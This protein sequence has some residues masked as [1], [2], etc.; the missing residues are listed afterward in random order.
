LLDL[1]HLMAESTNMIDFMY[2]GQLFAERFAHSGGMRLD[3][4]NATRLY[5]HLL[6]LLLANED[7]DTLRDA[8]DRLALQDEQPS[9]GIPKL[10][11]DK[12]DQLLKPCIYRL[13][14]VLSARFTRYGAHEDFERAVTIYLVVM[15]LSE[16]QP[17]E[18]RCHPL[19]ILSSLYANHY[20]AFGDVADLDVSVS[21]AERASGLAKE[22]SPIK[23]TALA[24]LANACGVRFRALSNPTDLER[25]IST[26]EVVDTLT[27]DTHPMKF[28]FLYG[29]G[30]DLSFFASADADRPQ[31]EKAIELQKRGIA[32]LP[33]AHRDLYTHIL[34]LV[35]SLRSHYNHFA[36]LSSLDGVINILR[37]TLQLVSQ[38]QVITRTATLHQIGEALS[39][40]HAHCGESE[41]LSRAI[42]F[43]SQ[44][45]TIVSDSHPERKC[46]LI[47]LSR[48]LLLL[49]PPD[50]DQA[51]SILQGY[52]QSPQQDVGICIQY[53]AVLRSRRKGN[54][55]TESVRILQD[56]FDNFP[57]NTTASIPLL[58]AL[59]KSLQAQVM[60]RS[61]RPLASDWDSIISI[62]QRVVDAT[63]QDSPQRAKHLHDLGEYHAQV[64]LQSMKPLEDQFRD[65]L[66]ASMDIAAV[67]RALHAYRSAATGD[68]G[69]PPVRL[70][71][72]FAWANLAGLFFDTRGA[73]EGY[74]VALDMFTRTAWLQSGIVGRF[75]ELR[76]FPNVAREAAHMAIALDE[77]NAAIEWLETGRSVVWAQVRA[78]RAPLDQVRAVDSGLA[79]EI[80]S[81]S[82]ALDSMGTGTRSRSLAEGLD[83]GS[84]FQL[85]HQ[86]AGKWE[87]LVVKARALPGLTTFLLPKKLDE[88]ASVANT[89][90]I[91]FLT[92][93][94]LKCDALI[95]TKEY[96]SRGIIH[97]PLN[98]MDVDKAEKLSHSLQ[99][100][101]GDANLLVRGSSGARGARPP[102][103]Q[104]QKSFFHKLLAA[105]WMHIVK[106]VLDALSLEVSGLKMY[107][108]TS[109]DRKIGLRS[110][111][112]ASQDVVVSHR[113]IEFPPTSRGRPISDKR[114]RNKSF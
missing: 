1:D 96:P 66:A 58:R 93:F 114:A 50:L 100:F 70:H 24:N 95:I 36:V 56:V 41:D 111:Q 10:V 84:A 21:L 65:G 104:T 20:T 109:I 55:V 76:S 51:A 94:G 49:T 40:R 91:V 99:K 17:S 113:A 101:L 4:D 74:S 82:A 14:Q 31:L 38:D 112:D 18:E 22:D 72:A 92:V 53:A 97:V 62:A 42:S 68:S 57:P 35:N 3:L 30:T 52:V 19:R 5:E 46:I 45:C 67:K 15:A 81:V 32:L 71:A 33:R 39:L 44:A 107:I 79:D 102:G 26:H 75:T 34:G 28:Q 90:P 16:E 60:S 25:C 7:V 85:Y 2:L 6:T 110:G 61:T 106:P 59:C 47:D 86:L 63:P 8:G 83:I 12:P 13:G 105:L 9:S 29:Y 54:D 64:W 77:H 87:A 78:L 80:L 23:V 73:F 27:P 89:G 11:R 108:K 103:R 98:G 88:L 69:P 43:L 37:E 48:C